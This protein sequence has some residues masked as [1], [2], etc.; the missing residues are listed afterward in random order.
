LV[1]PSRTGRLVPVVRLMADDS[2]AAQSASRTLD[3]PCAFAPLTVMIG[4]PGSR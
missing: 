4:C 2:R 1:S 3:L